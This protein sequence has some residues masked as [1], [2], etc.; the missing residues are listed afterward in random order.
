MK[1]NA[2]WLRTGRRQAG[3]TTGVGFNRRKGEWKMEE[4]RRKNEDG[5]TKTKE[6]GRMG[7][8]NLTGIK[9]QAVISFKNS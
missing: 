1:D 3:H 8:C 2:I 5:R 7:E 6:G 4:G 9:N